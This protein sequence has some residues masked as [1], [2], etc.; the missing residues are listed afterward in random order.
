MII[1]IL[2]KYKVSIALK[3]TPLLFVSTVKLGLQI[4]NNNNTPVPMLSVLIQILSYL[5]C[6]NVK[7]QSSLII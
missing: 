7:K 1:P 5:R 2:L 3:E 4:V 6:L